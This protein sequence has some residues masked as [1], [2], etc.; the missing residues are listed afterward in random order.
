MG[1]AKR[2][3]AFD[4]KNFGK[5]SKSKK[6]FDSKEINVLKES[7]FIDFDEQEDDDFYNRNKNLIRLKITF[8]YELQAV[9]KDDEKVSESGEMKIG[10]ESDPYLYEE[11]SIF[12]SAFEAAMQS[13]HYMFEKKGYGE[14]SEVTIAIRNLD[15]SY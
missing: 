11:G 7:S 14:L 5:K 3:K 6:G 8:E 9:T 4:P 2:R 1:E 10:T 13:F 15:V 12:G